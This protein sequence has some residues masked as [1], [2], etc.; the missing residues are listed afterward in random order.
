MRMLSYQTIAVKISGDSVETLP[1]YSIMIARYPTMEEFTDTEGY[2]DEAHSMERLMELIKAVRNIRGEHNIDQGQKIP[3]VVCSN[4]LF[5]KDL[6]QRED[7]LLMAL[8]KVNQLRAVNHYE[9]KGTVASGVCPGA[10]LFIPLSDLIDVEEE[11]RRISRNLAKALKELDKAENKL[12]NEGFLK[13]APHEVVAR[14]RDGR[15]ELLF[16]LEKLNR[17]LKVLGST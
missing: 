12:N 1:P 10:E 13:G 6:V 16:K 5:F 2:G 17:N 14:M 11:R 4:D 3:L 15:R 8:A 9:R 7:Q